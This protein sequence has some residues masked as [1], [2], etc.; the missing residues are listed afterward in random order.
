MNEDRMRLVAAGT[1]CCFLCKFCKGC[2]VKPQ[3]F[4]DFLSA[5]QMFNYMYISITTDK[6]TNSIQ[7]LK[8]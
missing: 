2:I 3:P 7:I 8:F 5:Y 1:G 6:V 4:D